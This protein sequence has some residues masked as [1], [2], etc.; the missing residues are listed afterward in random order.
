MDVDPGVRRADLRAD[1]DHRDHARLTATTTVEPDP[2]TEE[3][4]ETP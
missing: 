1:S 2:P 4:D 3:T